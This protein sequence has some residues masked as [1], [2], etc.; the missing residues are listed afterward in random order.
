TPIV[1]EPSVS[2]SGPISL[3]G[4]NGDDELFDDSFDTLEGLGLL[5]K[6][7]IS[8]TLSQAGGKISD[9]L[10]R[11]GGLLSPSKPTP[12]AASAHAESSSHAMLWTLL[13]GSALVGTVWYLARKKKGRRR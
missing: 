1:D 5:G 12:A 13:A 10:S 4:G 11:I 3:W 6:S 9:V 7:D 2:A 8:D